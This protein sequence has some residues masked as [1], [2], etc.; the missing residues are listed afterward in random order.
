MCRG[1]ARRGGVGGRVD[2][3]QNGKRRVRLRDGEEFFGREEQHVGARGVWV[4]IEDMKARQI[5]RQ[6]DVE[7][8]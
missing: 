5:T 1:I 7:R 8:V 3:V 2:D 4:E 6:E